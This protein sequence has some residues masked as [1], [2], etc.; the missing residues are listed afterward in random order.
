MCIV[1]ELTYLVR[2]VLHGPSQYYAMV[3]SNGQGTK[4]AR[5][6]VKKVLEIEERG[7]NSTIEQRKDDAVCSVSNKGLLGLLRVC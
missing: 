1:C 6:D 5:S 2:G 7:I 3:G 4:A